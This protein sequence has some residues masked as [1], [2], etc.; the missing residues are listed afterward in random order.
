ME[1]FMNNILNIVCYFPLAGMILIMLTK[2]DNALAVKWIA[3]VTAFIGFIISIPLFT[4]FDDPL[5][6]SRRRRTK[7]PGHW[8]C[9]ARQFNG[10]ANGARPM[11]R[12]GFGCVY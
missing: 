4:A 9:R 6:D 3:N 10:A 8:N 5:A 11:D 1:F 2:R 7:P 12:L